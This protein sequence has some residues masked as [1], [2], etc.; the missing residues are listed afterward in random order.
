[1]F[2]LLEG[3]FL[4]QLLVAAFIAVAF[5]LLMLIFMMYKLF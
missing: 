4:Y 3:V 1:M 5:F 2:R